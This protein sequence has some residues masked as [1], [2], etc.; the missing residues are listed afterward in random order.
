MHPKSGKPKSVSCDEIVS[1]VKKLLKGFD[2]V[3]NFRCISRKNL[4]FS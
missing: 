1:K 4:M 3:S 2:I